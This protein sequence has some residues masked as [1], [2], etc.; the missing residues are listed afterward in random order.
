MNRRNMVMGKPPLVYRRAARLAEEVTRA[1]NGGGDCLWRKTSVYSS[2][3]T[4]K[5][6]LA[7]RDSAR[8]DARRARNELNNFKNTARRQDLR[9][10][11]PA[12]PIRKKEKGTL[13]NP[14]WEADMEYR[15]DR[16]ECCR[17]WND[18]EC[19]WKEKCK[20]KHWCS[21]RIGQGKACKSKNHF[22]TGHM[23]H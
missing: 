23:D 6:Y 19:K 9:S 4:A 20:Y 2:M 14:E 13:R 18:G 16:K 12:S 17:D 1:Y 22:R 10:S 7:E 21:A 5:K 11:G 3:R 15:E 8:E